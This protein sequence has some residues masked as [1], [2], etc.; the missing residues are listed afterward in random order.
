MFK[1]SD[2]LTLNIL[3]YSNCRGESSLVKEKETYKVSE[4]L[5]AFYNKDKVDLDIY[6]NIFYYIYELSDDIK[7]SISCLLK[8]ESLIIHDEESSYLIS[9][10]EE[11]NKDEIIEF[12]E[13]ILIF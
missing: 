4:V 7:E 2:V 13:S 12:Y 11:M 10:N 1:L 8:G 6:H 3:T 5:T 9:L